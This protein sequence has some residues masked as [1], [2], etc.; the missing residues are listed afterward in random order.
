MPQ[1]LGFFVLFALQ[2]VIAEVGATCKSM[3]SCLAYGVTPCDRTTQLCP[4]CLYTNTKGNNLCY[5]RVA[6]TKI[7][8]FQGT[9]DD[10]CTFSTALV[11]VLIVLITSHVRSRDTGYHE[12]NV[13]DT[14][15]DDI[16]HR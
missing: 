8:P 14:S 3:T 11:P 5:D 10:C 13:H 12:Q 4:P 7:C 6:G 9:L 16:G 2:P 15:N 1:A